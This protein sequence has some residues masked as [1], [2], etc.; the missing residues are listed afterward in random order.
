MSV[1]L[2]ATHHDPDGRLFD[3]TRSALPRLAAIFAGMA[4]QATHATQPGALELLSG[5][6]ATLRQES[7]DQISGYLLLGR[8]RRA[9]LDL[10]LQLDAPTVMLCDFDRAL[11]WVDHAPDELERVVAQLAGHDFTVLGRTDRAFGSHPRVQRDTEAII[12]TVY[13]TVS[14]FEWD[15]TAAAR[16]ISRRAAAAILSG[17]PDETIG[18]DV[19]WPLFLQR[20]GGFSMSYVATEG[21]AFETA[22]RYAD[23]VAAAGGVARWIAQIDADPRQWAQRLNMARV[24]VEAALPYHDAN[25]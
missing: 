11:Y 15:V 18:V 13:A 7:A 9:A 2:A 1:V 17:C 21:L 6:G 19:S 3:Q 16:G 25:Q 8:S 24:E 4:I 14:G 5:A 20:A 23:E 22:D 12:N 10:A